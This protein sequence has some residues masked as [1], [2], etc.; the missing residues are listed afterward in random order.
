[1]SE[2]PKTR[3]VIG[4]ARLPKKRRLERRAWHSTLASRG[5]VYKRAE[6][7]SIA[8]PRLGTFI[9]PPDAWQEL[10]RTFDMCSRFAAKVRLLAPA[11]RK[12]AALRNPQISERR[13][14][15]AGQQTGHP[16]ACLESS[17]AWPP[18]DFNCLKTFVD[19]RGKI[20]PDLASPF[21]KIC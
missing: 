20:C 17:E 10:Q 7:W 4:R 21:P 1:V 2:R 3:L 12:I 6:P 13:L 9:A 8:P 16:A 14:V 18:A 15:A 5:Y 11:G 19:N